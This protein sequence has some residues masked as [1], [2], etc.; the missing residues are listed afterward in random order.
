MK[1]EKIYLKDHFP[2]LGENGCNAYVD[3]YIPDT[4]MEHNLGDKKFP[5]IVV[6]PGGGYGYTSER[7]GDVIAMQFLPQG[8]RVFVV[9]YSVN[10][11][12]F[13]Q[14]LR[15][16]AGA[17]ELIHKY[18]EEWHADASRVAIIG[19]SAGGHCAAQYSNRYDCPEVR[20]MFPESKP[21]QASILSYPVITADPKYTH[22][23]TVNTFVGG[24]TPVDLEEKGV[25]CHLV[26][27]DKTPPTFLWHTAEDEL[28]AVENSLLYAKALREHKIPFELHI[29]PFGAHGLSIADDQVYVEPLNAKAARA[30]KWVDDMKSWLKMMGF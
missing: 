13:P 12:G 1:F 5:C 27:S 9:K 11:H 2:Q 15:E 30:G 18:A 20:E 19:F 24:H 4:I 3:C 25:S 10:P 16:V 8:Y 23:G 7:E 26:V 17:M 22:A 21:V 14:Q 6:C 29:Y 28:V